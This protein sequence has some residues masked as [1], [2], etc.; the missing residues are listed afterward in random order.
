M[1]L[2]PTIAAFT[3]R[4][5]ALR[6]NQPL[7]GLTRFAS[8]TARVLPPYRGVVTLP[9]GIKMLLD[10]RQSAERWLL[11]SGNYQ[12][13]VTAWVRRHVAIGRGAYCLDVGANLGFYT[14][15]M[16]QR[17]GAAGKI[18]VF[19][20]NPTL[21]V[22][23]REQAALNSFAQVQ[24]IEKAVHHQ[25][26]KLTFYIANDPGKS[27]IY[28]DHATVRQEM[29]V[30][31][32]TLDRFIAEAGWD[33]VDV[34]KMDIEGNDCYGLLGARRTLERFRPAVIFEY[35]ASTP[36][37][38]TRELIDV[39]TALRYRLAVLRADGTTAP[40]QHE[41]VTTGHLDVIAEALS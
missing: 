1:K 19:E 38:A 32:I 18:A 31:A 26:G 36:F 27:S 29:E 22:R 40:F 5:Q 16:A 23:L 13:S 25:A 28:A 10:S 30:E 15:L 11:F 2:L 37:D 17:T 12:P 3:R 7:R 8:I 34:I 35:T 4:L 6:P 9:D 41:Q 39:F 14:L 24:V 33:R 21:A 20:P